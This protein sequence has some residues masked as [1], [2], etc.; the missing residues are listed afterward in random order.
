[1]SSL[2]P[3]NA[4]LGGLPRS[5]E[6]SVTRT[7]GFNSQDEDY[8]SFLVPSETSYTSGDSSFS[9]VVA[10]LSDYLAASNNTQDRSFWNAV[11]HNAIGELDLPDLAST[12]Y[13]GKIFVTRH[14][15]AAGADILRQNV[16]PTV[17]ISPVPELSDQ[18]SRAL[19]TLQNIEEDLDEG[20][21]HPSYRLIADVESLV[22]RL[23]EEMDIPLDVEAM[24]EG[25]I[26]LNICPKRRDMIFI[27]CDADGSAYCM[28]K[29]KNNRE[30]RTYE[31]IGSLPDQR[32]KSA[33]KELS[34]SSE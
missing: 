24:P 16:G 6:E 34:N 14:V 30:E 33:L 4:V 27:H 26:I 29:L 19:S 12:T 21:V 8:V 13:V 32:I 7:D 1:M 17:S 18:C 22:L 5:R 23:Y 11:E 25:D 28:V 31:S 20:D 15:I 9:E 10:T 3:V 2:S